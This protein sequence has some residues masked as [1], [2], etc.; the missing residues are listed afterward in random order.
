MQW[1]V[2]DTVI[3]FLMFWL[4]IQKDFTIFLKGK[5]QNGFCVFVE[6]KD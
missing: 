1:V 4:I 6:R 5:N 2:K 3:H